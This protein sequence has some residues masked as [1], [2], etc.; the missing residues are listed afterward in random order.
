MLVSCDSC[1]ICSSR[2]HLLCLA[3]LAHISWLKH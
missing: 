2:I 1:A 3:K